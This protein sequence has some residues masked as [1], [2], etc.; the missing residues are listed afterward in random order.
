MSKGT[1]SDIVA[2]VLLQW[3]NWNSYNMTI[4]TFLI[5]EKG[6]YLIGR[7]LLHGEHAFPLR[8]QSF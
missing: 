5:S 1:S 2:K 6:S 8:V 7:N 3:L 4:I